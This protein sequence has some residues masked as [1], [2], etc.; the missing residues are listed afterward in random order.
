MKHLMS[1]AEFLNESTVNEAKL[2]TIDKI[3]DKDTLNNRNKIA[4]ML[5]GTLK[6]VAML[7]QD[8]DSG[9]NPYDYIESKVT[10]WK[11]V[12]KEFD[13]DSDEVFNYSKK[14]NVI[15]EDLDGYVNYYFLVKDLSKLK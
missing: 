9:S 3:S 1:F 15:S 11:D 10:D 14:H 5:G 8:E 4:K 2:Y 12:S 13:T 7:D 6:D